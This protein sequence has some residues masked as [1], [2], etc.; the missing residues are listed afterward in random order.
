MKET[1]GIRKDQI[2]PPQHGDARKFFVTGV[3][4]LSAGFK[5]MDSKVDFLFY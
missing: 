3:K 1:D 5:Y 4:D 2:Y